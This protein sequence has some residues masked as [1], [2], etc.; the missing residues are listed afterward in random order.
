[1]AEETT[2]S[3]GAEEGGTAGV[4]QPARTSDIDG[5]D[6]PMPAPKSKPPSRRGRNFAAKRERERT[7]PARDARDYGLF[8]LDYAFRTIGGRKAALE[9]AELGCASD[10]RLKALMLAFKAQKPN[11]Q[12]FSP[13]LLE[14]LCVQVGL[15]PSE[16]LGICTM[17]AHKHQ[18]MS[19]ANMVTGAL[20]GVV[21]VGLIEAM[22]PEG[23]Q[24]RKLI[25]E[26]STFLPTKGPGVAVQINTG[27]PSG[28]GAQLPEFRSL[29]ELA[30]SAM[31][32]VALP[33]ASDEPRSEVVDGEILPPDLPTG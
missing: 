10:E 8:T 4:A 28:T 16:F 17:L 22:K 3:D 31:N 29:S 15:D 20:E 14:R 26:H 27:S 7:Q 2:G 30:G 13:K 18:L 21:Q 6:F 32:R 19:V 1:M 11:V 23:F 25:Y 5:F 9:L 24:D 12:K 33:P